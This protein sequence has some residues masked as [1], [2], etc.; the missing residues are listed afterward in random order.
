MKKIYLFDWGDTL[1][2]DFPEQTGKMCN[3]PEVRAVEGALEV[4]K[5]LSKTNSV[6]IATNAAD[7]TE[8]D[9]EQA[10]VRVGLAPYI[11][12]YFCKSNLGLGKGTPEFFRKIQ[13][14]FDTVDIPLVMVGDNY[15]NDI[16]P[17]LEA[18][19]N[20]IWFNPSHQERSMSIG[21]KQIHHLSELI[22]R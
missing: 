21:V 19:L 9:I 16:L 1:M 15:N 17:A 4:L 14:K 3:W 7:S 12:G 6:Y 20:A 18:G 8:K 5:H 11:D 10:F 22:S 2:V 13:E